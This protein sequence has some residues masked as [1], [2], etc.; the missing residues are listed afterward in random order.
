VL[1]RQHVYLFHVGVGDEEKQMKL[2]LWSAGS[3]IVDIDTS[4]PLEDIQV[5]MLDDVIPKGILIHYLKSDTQGYD[6]RVM[7]GARQL[8]LHNRVRLTTLEFYL[9]G[10]LKAGDNPLKFIEL[11][12]QTYKLICF[13]SRPE[14]GVGANHREDILGY[15]AEVKGVDARTHDKWGFFDDL[16]CLNVRYTG[17]YS[18]NSAFD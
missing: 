6:H 2:S 17:Q 9:K 15:W 4:K 5:V 12:T 8:F 7:L 11:L 16:T 10:L 3:S 18:N 14:S 13:D 1:K